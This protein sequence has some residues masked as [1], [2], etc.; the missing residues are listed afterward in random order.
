MYMYR[1]L[2]AHIQ[3]H[4]IQEERCYTCISLFLLS[5]YNDTCIYQFSV[6]VR[7]TL[8]LGKGSAMP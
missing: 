7:A 8:T 2:C 4:D 1:A 3:F 5:M 6:S